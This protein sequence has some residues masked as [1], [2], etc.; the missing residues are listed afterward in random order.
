[1]AKEKYHHGTLK[2]EM[3]EKGLQLLNRKGYEGFSLRKVAVLCNVSHAAPY[4]HF[5]SKEELISAITLQVTDSFRNSLQEAVDRHSRDPR[6]Q[7]L[8]L[9]KQYVRFM[10]E[11][12]EHLKFLFLSKNTQPVFIREGK[13][14]PPEHSPFC[15]FKKSAEDYLVSAGINPGEWAGDILTMWSVVH[16]FSVLIVNNNIRYE[17]DYLDLLNG[18]LA[19]LL[20][21]QGKRS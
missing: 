7:I 9:G 4:K 21:S 18:M 15:V 5:K 10:V 20:A 12:P 13:F 3:I 11:N 19:D 14:Y 8:E 16:G 6:I 2:Q 17:G 1:M